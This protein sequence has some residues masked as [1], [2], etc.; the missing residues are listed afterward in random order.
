MAASGFTPIQLYRT[1]TAS[2]APTSGNLADGE[3]AINTLD[4][5][6]YFKNS[7][8]TVKLLA[9]AAGSAGD[10]V[11]PAS[12]TDSAL[13]AFNGTTGKLIKQA[14]TVT[15]AQGGT[16]VTTSTGTGNVVLSNSPTLVTPALGTPSALVGTNITGTA[17]GLTAGT[18]TTNA[19]LTGAVTSTGN[20]TSLGSFTSANLAGA[21]TDETGSGSAVFAT[22]PTLVTPIL[23]TPTSVTLTNATG[24]PLTTG[25]T[26]TL[27]IA[28][29]GTGQTTA[30]AAFNALAPSQT[31]NSG[32]V[33]TTDGSSTSWTTSL[34]AAGSN[35]QVQFNSSGV[36]GASANLTFDGSTLTVNGIAVTR[37][38]NSVSTNTI[39]HSIMQF[40]TTGNNN[41]A[42]GSNALYSNTTGF[43]NT[44]IGSG[45]MFNH[46]TGESNTAVGFF[47][48]RSNTTGSNN[49]AFGSQALASNTTA[50]NNVAIG[51][52]ALTN[53]TSASN[54]AVGFYA[55]RNLTTGAG[56]IAIG[57]FAGSSVTTG[58]NNTLIG[59][60]QGSTS[61]AGVVAINA[62]VSS[63][64]R[65]YIDSSGNVGFNTTSPTAAIDHTG[66][67]LRLRTSRT[68]A[69]ASATG[70]TGEICWDSNYV[71]VCVATDTW[72]R[73]ALSTW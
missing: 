61:L 19:N 38:A 60:F 36:F 57:E 9:S 10:V 62:G 53:S 48:L 29:G 41:V 42:V 21:L 35:T 46:T 66:S 40:N 24:L 63:T 69:S 56:N 49:T 1:T 30:N 7:A 50:S 5:K 39:I 17:A 18:V 26:G 64:T 22:S 55:L 45:S 44:A 28:N 12:A 67:T 23:G 13:V 8:G 3:L 52:E 72:K 33:L 15:V 37:G 6:L 34:T 47:S 31:G 54:T 16:G 11:G 43:Y 65:V 25:V 14:A 71:Y 32:K 27:P 20:A 4:E 58:S 73:S 2:A 70:T 51:E 59:G 68:P